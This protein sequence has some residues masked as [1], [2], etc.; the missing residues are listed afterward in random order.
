MTTKTRRRGVALVIFLGLIAFVFWLGGLVEKPTLAAAPAEPA[1][2]AEPGL[3]P[4]GG[5]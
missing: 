1:K 4:A 3:V 5:D 2:A